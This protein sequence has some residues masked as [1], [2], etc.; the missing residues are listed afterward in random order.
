MS[1]K[2]LIKEITEGSIAWEQNIVPGDFLLSVNDSEVIDVFDYRYLCQD[3]LIKL[4]IQKSD[5]SIGTYELVKG[6]DEDIGL[7]FEEG[8]MDTYR[9]CMNKCIFCFIDQMPKGMRETLYFKDDD[10]RLSFLQGNYVTLTNLTDGDIDRIIKYR[11]EPINISFQTTNPNLRCMMLNNRFAG[12][13]LKKADRLFDADIT[14]NGQIVLCKG[15]NDGDELERSLNDLYKYVPI[16]E[17]L[18]IVPVGL[19]KFRE[20]L[21]PLEPLTEEDA[22][23]V[24]K[25]VRRWQ[26]KAYK[27]YGLH[28]VHA[29]DEIY[30]IAN[31]DLPDEDTYDGYL[32]IENG[33][34][35]IRLFETEF[36]EALSDIKEA[37]E[38]FNPGIFDKINIKKYDEK[39]TEKTGVLNISSLKQK[40]DTGREVSLV[41][42]EISYRYIKELTDKFTDIFNNYKIN[43]YS[44]K[45]EFFG[46]MITVTG[47]ITGE[48][49]IKQL[50]GKNIGE[51]LL[52]PEKMLRAQTDVFL[53]NT[54]LSD[55]EKTLHSDTLIVKSNGKYLIESIIGETVYV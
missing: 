13:A 52:I 21:Y 4:K 35:T 43:V 53:D 34:G 49:I 31:E 48:D 39:I 9:S 16:L 17:S 1:T 28:F 10:M 3:S 40:L 18:S 54:R 42:G 8:L 22:K 6:E 44:I 51:A 23:N 30:I 32:Q 27:E 41:T 14:M 15:I 36:N 7:I 38:S 24:L 5:G 11:L 50:N 19:T 12:T 33:V 45:N 25:T 20:G 29:S 47:L 37:Y 26:G 2:H 46:E 55:I